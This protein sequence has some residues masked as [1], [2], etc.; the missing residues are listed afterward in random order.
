MTRKQRHSIRQKG[1]DCSQTGAYFVANC[2][3]NRLCLFGYIEDGMREFSDAG[4]LLQT[5][6][7]KTS[8]YDAALTPMRSSSC[9]IMFMLSLC[10]RDF[11]DVKGN[12]GGCLYGM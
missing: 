6:W 12:C 10:C 1:Y 8:R 4:E 11:A 7:K 2:T 5:V 9:P 3:R